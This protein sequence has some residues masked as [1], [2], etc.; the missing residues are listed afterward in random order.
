MHIRQIKLSNI[1]GFREVNLDLTRPD[2]SLAG[3]TVLAGRNGSGKST[4]LK[5]IAL[6][7]A[8]PEAARALQPSFG[9]WIRAGSREASVVVPLKLFDLPSPEARLTWIRRVGS[10]EP[11]LLDGSP[12]IQETIRQL[13]R[14][15]LTFVDPA[16]QSA[17]ILEQLSNLSRITSETHIGNREKLFLTAYGPYRRL[18]G[19]T[20]DA[21]RL[22]TGPEPIARVVSLFRE[23]ASLIESVGWLREIYLWRL[24]NKPGA[25]ELE[26]AVLALLNDGLLP[27]GVRVDK[28]D[29]DGLW[30]FQRDVRLPLRELSDGY[31]TVAALVLDIV[32]HL[33]RTF[34]TFEIEQAA[35]ETGS[36]WRV[37]HSGVVLIDEA[38]NHLHVSWQQRIGFWLKRHFPNIQFLVTSHSPFICQAADPGG[39][40]RLPAPGEERS[41]ERV[42]EDLY[43]TVVHGTL[44]DAVLT[45]L[46]GLESPYSEE[47]ERLRAEVARLEAALQ[48]GKATD[49]D[50]SSLEELR[51]QLPRTMPSAIE[52]ALRALAVEK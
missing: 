12:E 6:A 4:L 37:L 22:M 49:A 11:G 29:S 1:R 17:T 31:R 24:E 26:K 43:N 38:D 41:V 3:W 10:S 14:E 40:I 30:V 44:D 16:N 39:L 27:D 7:V 28:V 25:V 23:D 47:T 52:Q 51:S 19:Q 2:G 18:S 36:F 13:Q 35:D 34:G 15:L 50:R 5:A 48:M 9:D 33:H 32:R 46:F 8:G 42:S 45:E 20:E 21:Q